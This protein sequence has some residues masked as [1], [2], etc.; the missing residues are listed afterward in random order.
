MGYL[1]FVKISWQVYMSYGIDEIRHFCKCLGNWG[2]LWF[3]SY[4]FKNSLNP[5]NST[6]LKLNF[7]NI[8]WPYLTSPNFK[9]P[10][11][12]PNRGFHPWSPATNKLSQLTRDFRTCLGNYSNAEMEPPTREKLRLPPVG[13]VGTMKVRLGYLVLK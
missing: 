6:P 5:G 8:N 3:F 11:S 10:I 1:T 9:L 4:L 7:K 13:S 12:E 2:N